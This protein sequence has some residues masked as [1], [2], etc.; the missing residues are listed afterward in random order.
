MENFSILEA[1]EVAINMEEEGI[2][3]YALAGE[4]AGDPETKKLFALLQEREHD[5]IQAFKQ[6]HQQIAEKEGDAD[7]GLWLLDV[8]TASYFRAFVESTVFPV[9]G[10]AEQAIEGLSG[11]ADALALALRIEKDSILFYRELMEHSPWP[12]ARELLEKV[13]AEERR[14]VRFIHERIAAL[15]A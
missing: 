4:R 1:V 9:K 3:F 15:A 6:L 11:P 12:A 13:V 7:A 5:H 8:D 10:A 14:H 2:R